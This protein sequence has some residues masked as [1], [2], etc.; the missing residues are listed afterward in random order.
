MSI[1]QDKAGFWWLEIIKH[2]N[3]Q[4]IKKIRRRCTSRGDARSKA[5][6]IMTELESGT[7]GKPEAPT[8][9]PTTVADWQGPY[10]TMCAS[11]Y[12]PGELRNRKSKVAWIVKRWGDVNI[13]E[14]G[15]R[16]VVAMV[17]ELKGLGR[18]GS[19]INHYQ[20][21]MRDYLRQAWK[22]GRRGPV[23]IDVSSLP[24]PRNRVHY[25][26]QDQFGHILTCGHG[27]AVKGRWRVLVY[28]GAHAGLRLGEVQ[29]LRWDD[30]DFKQRSLHV[31][32]SIDDVG[33]EWSQQ[34]TKNCSHRTIPLSRALFGCLADWETHC[35]GRSD[36]VVDAFKDP[37][38]PERRR[39]IQVAWQMIL[40]E[41]QLFE[42]FP[43]GSRGLHL[44]RHTFA[45]WL[46][47]RGTPLEVIRQLMG[48]SNIDM[49]TRYAHMA[50][51]AAV[52]AVECL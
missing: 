21:I 25:L 6:R 17:N 37:S 2:P 49:V 44:L 10:L 13:G 36:W 4:P 8:K 33:E 40:E 19:T 48:H 22:A 31:R 46:A 26:T 3:G 14:L 39:Q 29:G 38:R 34:E 50:P 32:R 23:D 15:Q 47:Q 12:R 51:G 30:I 5:A 45:S 27:V 28:L 11:K 16:E 43:T 41:A 18:K 9:G 20:L 1:Y 52:E 35:G 7:F 24:M 42:C